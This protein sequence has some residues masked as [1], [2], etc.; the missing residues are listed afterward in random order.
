MWLWYQSVMKEPQT[1]TTQFSLFCFLLWFLKRQELKQPVNRQRLN[2]GA[3]LRTSRR[4]M[5]FYSSRDSTN[6]NI[7]LE[8]L[9]TASSLSVFKLALNV[10]N[11]LIKYN[12]G[13]FQIYPTSLLLSGISGW[14]TSVQSM[15]LWYQSVLAVLAWR[16]SN[17]HHT[18]QFI[19]FPALNLKETGAKT[20]C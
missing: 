16:N 5:S 18:L 20:A 1:F 9:T 13:L 8:T 10:K 4:Y 3:A 19:L 7:E 2:W 17:F 15:W 11:K 14:R 6:V 12:L